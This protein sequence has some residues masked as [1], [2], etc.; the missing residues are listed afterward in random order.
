MNRPRY[1]RAQKIAVLKREIGFRNRVY[2]GLI[3]RGRM[4][5]EEADFQ[6][7]VMEE[8]LAEQER[9]QAEEAMKMQPDLFG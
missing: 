8:L 6:T 5:Q 7:G 2:P 4:T 1:T 3:A 9:L